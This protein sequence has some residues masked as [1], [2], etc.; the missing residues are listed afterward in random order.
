M[1]QSIYLSTSTPWIPN[2]LNINNTKAHSSCIRPFLIRSIDLINYDNLTLVLIKSICYI[3][4]SPWW[5]YQEENTTKFNFLIEQQ[6]HTIF[7]L[8]FNVISHNNICFI[9]KTMK[10][11]NSL[12]YFNKSRYSSD[13]SSLYAGIVY[14]YW[15]KT[16][17]TE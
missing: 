11:S 1:I 9:V 8:H 3:F 6:N 15:V 16:K 17:F 2:Q 13:R 14:L 10:C 4:P 5:N 12:D 7:F